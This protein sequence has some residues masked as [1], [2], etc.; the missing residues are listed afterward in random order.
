MIQLLPRRHRP[1]TVLFT[2]GTYVD[3]YRVF[4][5]QHVDKHINVN[6][7]PVIVCLQHERRDVVDSVVVLH[8]DKNIHYQSCEASHEQIDQIMERFTS[9]KN[10]VLIYRN[11]TSNPID[12]DLVW[13]EPM[14]VWDIDKGNMPRLQ[15]IVVE[16]DGCR[17]VCDQYDVVI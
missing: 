9:D 17:V 8:N 6:K 1:L 13:R 2:N 3:W 12:C 5:D 4:N 10:K 11:G 14:Y 16:L 15:D 7:V